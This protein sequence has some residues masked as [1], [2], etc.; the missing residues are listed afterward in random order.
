MNII[1]KY[2]N[3]EAGEIKYQIGEGCESDQVMPQWHANL[4]GLGEIYDK[5][6][7]KKALKSLYRN[8]FKSMR[9]V[10]NAWRIFSL[11]DEEGLIICSWPE[12]K[13]SAIPLTYSTETMTGFEYQAAV[14]ML[15]EG[16]YEEGGNII[17]AVRSR[18]DGK[19]RNPWNEMECGSNYARS[20]A[21]YSIL[22]ASSGFTYDGVEKTVGFSPLS[23]SGSYFFSTGSSWGIVKNRQDG[24]ELKVYYD[25][26][27]ISG[28][29]TRG[30]KVKKILVE[31][32]EI[33]LKQE[34]DKAYTDKLLGIGE[35]GIL[36]VFEEIKDKEKYN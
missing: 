20:M 12:G 9:E 3:E 1:K 4:I 8:H 29:K 31:S 16:L 21:S 13:K 10:Q 11:N 5:E 17:R 35:N 19:K 14:H 34:E 2:W 18:Y 30:Y 24:W 26:L 25:T 32:E 6:Q 33:L 15:Q 27:K 7:T 23:G 22:L 28:I 36:I